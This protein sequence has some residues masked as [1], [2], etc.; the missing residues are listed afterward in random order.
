MARVDQTAV[1]ADKAESSALCPIAFKNGPGIDEALA[2]CGPATL[3]AQKFIER[4]ELW[5]DD[6]MVIIAPGIRSDQ[7]TAGIVA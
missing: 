3:L 4:K 2:G 7:A 6:L 1:F 5:T